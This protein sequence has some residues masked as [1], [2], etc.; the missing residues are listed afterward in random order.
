MILSLNNKSPSYRNSTPFKKKS[1]ILFFS[2]RFGCAYAQLVSMEPL[3]SELD[4]SNI[5][6]VDI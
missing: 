6:P 2:G 5:Q 1:F 3:P 4:D